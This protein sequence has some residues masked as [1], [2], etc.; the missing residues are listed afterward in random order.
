M[1]SL[2]RISKGVCFRRTYL[3]CTIVVYATLSL[4]PLGVSAQIVGDSPLFIPGLHNLS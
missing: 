2:D 4:L 3:L 1:M